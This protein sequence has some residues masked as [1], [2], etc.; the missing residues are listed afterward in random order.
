MLAFAAQSALAQQNNEE[1]C[2]DGTPFVA[3][4]P[5]PAGYKARQPRPVIVTMRLFFMKMAHEYQRLPGLDS[6][7]WR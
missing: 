6:G 2:G 5:T 1:L 4:G 3:T 7:K